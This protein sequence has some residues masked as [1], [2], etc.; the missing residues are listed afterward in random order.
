MLFFFFLLCQYVFIGLRTKQTHTTQNSSLS[1]G[2]KEG[3]VKKKNHLQ[4]ISYTFLRY[5]HCKKSKIKTNHDKSLE[6]VIAAE[7]LLIVHDMA[8]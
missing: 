6:K 5:L 4:F 8:L 2:K 1:V 3:G 7:H